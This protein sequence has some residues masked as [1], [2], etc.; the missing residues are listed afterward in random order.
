VSD[1]LIE[2]AK[3]ALAIHKA[4]HRSGEVALTDLECIAP[5]LA[6]ALIDTPSPSAPSPEAVA[7]AALQWVPQRR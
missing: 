4:Q 1:D 2:R 3:A 5:D 6:R 7:R